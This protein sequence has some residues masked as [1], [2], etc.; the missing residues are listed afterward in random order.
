MANRQSD[1][2]ATVDRRQFFQRAAAAAVFPALIPAAAL[3]RG[4]RPAPSNRITVGCIGVGRMGMGDLRD[5]MNR[6]EVQVLAA[7]DVDVH[8]AAA[9]KEAVE[10]HYA[11]ESA[12]GS[13]KGCA[14][15]NEFE[16]IIARDD[17]DVVSIVTPDHWH[18]IPAIAAAKAG[19]DVFI[20]KPLSLTI[21]EGRAL[22]DAIHRNGRVFMVGSQQRSQ[23]NFRFICELARNGRLG[24]LHTVKV[25][26][27]TDPG[28]GLPA[29]MPVPK[30]LDYN[31][32]LGQAPEKPY[33]E[34]RVHP[35]EGYSRPGWLRIRDYGHGMITGWGAHHL[36]I[37]HWGMGTE[38]TG[39]VEVEGKGEYPDPAKSLWDVHG[40]FDITYTYANGMRMHVCDKNQ[41]GIRLE[42]SEGWAMVKRGAL[43]AEP[44]SLLD[45]EIG[46]NELHLYESSDHKGNFLECVKTRGLTVAPAEIA[47][48]SCTACILGSMAMELGR[49][50]RWNPDKEQFVD[51]PEAD[52]LLHRNT[53]APWSLS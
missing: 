45:T 5:F 31:R 18:I 37:G 9:A 21:P 51:D 47:H 38:Y 14:T 49:T 26:F 19:K 15:Y 52:K 39:P 43:R 41:Q 12:A 25:G 24:E 2:A 6:G 13:Y 22:S 44:A 3:G 53:R 48:R 16:E 4:D 10:K 30:G 8:R 17:I 40:A 1:T 46:P 34:T 35:Q 20:Q 33:T 7:C 28:C 23:R 27:G 11:K 50:L 32:W 42:G 36:D 29:E